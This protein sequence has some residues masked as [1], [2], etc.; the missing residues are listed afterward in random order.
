MGRPGRPPFFPELDAKLIAWFKEKREKHIA[1]TCK[2]LRYQ[3]RK[4]ELSTPLPADFKASDGYLFCWTK[5]HNIG[6]RCITHTGQAD[7]REK[8]EIAKL[9]EEF[10]LSLNMKTVE[11]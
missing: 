10:L 3:F 4:A 6:R 7:N 1:V 8:R 9:T 11:Y 2:S 5:R